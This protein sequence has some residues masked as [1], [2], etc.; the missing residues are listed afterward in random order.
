MNRIYVHLVHRCVIITYQLRVR[1]LDD[2]NRRFFPVGPSA[3]NEDGLSE[4]AGYNNFIVSDIVS[5]IVQGP[6]QQSFLTL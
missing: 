2:A 1:S 6:A 4:R 5:N 3:E